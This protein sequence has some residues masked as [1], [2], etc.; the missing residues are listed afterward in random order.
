MNT[1]FVLINAEGKEVDWIDPVE[2]FT[3]T[4]S[5]WEIDNGYYTYTF[6]KYKFPDHTGYVRIKV[7]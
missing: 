3:E 1:E 7:D 4:E 2:E 5:Y 6:D